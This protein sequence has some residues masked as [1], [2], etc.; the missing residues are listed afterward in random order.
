[1][2]TRTVLVPLDGSD[3]A[4]AAIAEARQLASPDSRLL[5]MRAASALTLPGTDAVDTQ[6][7][8]VREAEQYMEGVKTRLEREG[9]RGVETHVWYGPA[10]S[11]IVEAAGLYKVDLIVM[12][13]HG[14]SG[15][16][17]L[18]FGSVAESVLRG[19]GRPVLV[20][21]ESATACETPRGHAAQLSVRG[22]A[23]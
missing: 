13:T 7:A 23:A 2:R 5:L 12:T 18:V 9:V 1:M 19:T 4:E 22:S 3:T 14:R 10:S 20:V 8:A 17:R 16:G 6:L 21:R 15:L 11:A